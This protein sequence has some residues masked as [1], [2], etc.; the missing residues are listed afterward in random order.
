MLVA[1]KAYGEREIDERQ[2]L[3]FPIGLFGFEQ[4]RHFAL[5]DATQP[6]FYWLQSTEEVNTAFVLLDPLVFR[7]DYVLQVDAAELADIG[8]EDPTDALCL[9]IVTIPD[10]VR[11]MTANLQGPVVVNRSTRVARQ[12]ISYNPTWQVRHGIFQEIETAQRQI[13]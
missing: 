7:P 6:P 13:C 2:R 5:I 11:E 12:L 3:T 10:N 4:Y 8:I 9:A 1:T